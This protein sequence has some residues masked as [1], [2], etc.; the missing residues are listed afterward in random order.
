M[1]ATIAC[2]A[3]LWPGFAGPATAE[4]PVRS[5]ACGAPVDA[6]TIATIVALSD[7]STLR[8]DTPLAQAEDA[9]DRN[10]RI[11]ELLAAQGD[12]RGLF[13]LMEDTAATGTVLPML[14]SGAGL[15]DPQLDAQ[16]IL[17]YLHS[18][19]NAVHAEF[20]GAPVAWQWRHYFDLAADCSQSPAYAAMVGY[21]AHIGVDIPRAIANAG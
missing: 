13:A 16:F 15:T 10:Q 20:T 21:N 14:R 8:G 12:R 2:A 11:A 1:V 6:D 19:L 3:V 7:I 17:D 9:A 18:W 5:V 4:S